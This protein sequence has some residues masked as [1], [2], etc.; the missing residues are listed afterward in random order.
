MIGEDLTKG[1][2]VASC[3][4]AKGHF[5]HSTPLS[6][7]NPYNLVAESIFWW[8]K[9]VTTNSPSNFELKMQETDSIF[10]LNPLWL[11][12]RPVLTARQWP[13]NLR[14]TPRK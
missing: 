5:I 14:L 7:S 2:N 13:H 4:P 3:Q 10:E 9:I 12:S 11:Y 8:E 1:I 6:S